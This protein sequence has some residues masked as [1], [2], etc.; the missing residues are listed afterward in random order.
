MV[1]TRPQAARL[2]ANQRGTAIFVVVLVLALLSGIGLFAARVTGSVDAATGYARQAAQARGLAIFASQ[3]A[4]AVMTSIG[5]AMF[6]DVGTGKPSRCSATRYLP[7]VPCAVRYHQD[8]VNL[9]A[10]SVGSSTPLLTPQTELTEGSLGPRTGIASLAG[11]EGNLNIEFFERFQAPP[12]A[13]Q[14]AGSNPVG[15][16]AKVYEYSISASAQIRPIVGSANALW[17]GPNTESS[18]AN[19][20]TIR[21]YVIAP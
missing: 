12:G 6:M 7:N 1:T 16:M 14:D 13:G 3:V 19:V 15:T 10:V 9:S 17:C 20:Q 11:V 8:L 4:P 21:M 18:S 5:D 2:R